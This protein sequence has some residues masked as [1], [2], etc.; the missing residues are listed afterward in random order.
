M[1]CLS[2]SLFS[3]A[4][5]L[6]PGLPSPAARPNSTGLSPHT[7]T[8]ATP[9]PNVAIPPISFSRITP[10]LSVSDLAFAESAPLL[11][12]AR[13][14]HVVSVLEGKAHIPPLIP[15]SHTLHVP[16]TDAPFAELVG[17]LGPVV[18]WVAEVLR[19]T[20]VLPMEEV[21]EG[22]EV[23]EGAETEVLDCDTA[24]KPDAAFSGG[25][26]LAHSQTFFGEDGFAGSVYGN[27]D[28][29]GNGEGNPVHILIHCAQGISRSPAVAAAL[30]VALPLV[31]VRACSSL[32]EPESV[33]SS[34]PPPVCPSSTSC[35]ALSESPRSG[36]PASPTS[37]KPTPPLLRWHFSAP[38]A[39]IKLS[40]QSQPAPHSHSQLPSSS[41]PR[42][43]LSVPSS[44][45]P[46][47]T[48]RL[49]APAALAH[50][51]ARRPCARPNWGF[52]RQLGEWEGVCR[53]VGVD[54]DG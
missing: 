29:D 48:T 22:M 31:S 3:P 40:P 32:S 2:P 27:G 15:P 49:S 8:H 50:I 23:L 4:A 38:A 52:C 39:P 12:A 11:R 54:V 18:A 41:T 1:P 16:L 6:I 47:L 42:R 44:S 53:G 34:S 13:V 36:Y 7:P 33:L 30:L 19:G 24:L 10:H 46:R 26:D 5:P 51:A 35:A 14:T 17:A 20:E 9:A 43:H 25:A 28:G 37:T 21:L 45:S